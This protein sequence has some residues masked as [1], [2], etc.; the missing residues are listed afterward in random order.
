MKT[1]HILIHLLFFCFLTSP[2]LQAQSETA[3]SDSLSES[4]LMALLMGGYIDSVNQALNFTTGVVEL[5][6]GLASLTVP[7]GYKYL[8]PEQSEYVMTELW[9]N[10]AAETLGMLFPENDGPFS[11]STYAIDI[12]YNPA[13]FINDD[14]ADEIEY[15]ELLEEMQKDTREESKMREKMGMEAVRLV[16]WASQP[17]YDASTK[18]L[19]WAKELQFGDYEENTLNYNLLALG[20]KGYLQMNFIA[21][22]NQLERVK[23]DIPLIIPAINFEEGNR[24]SDFDP[25]LDEVAAIG[26]G[27][28]IAG[29]VLKSAGI[30]AI[31]AKFGKFIIVGLGVAG[32]AVWRFITGRRK[33]DE[34]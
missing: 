25:D 22:M 21:E 14:D 27:G 6:D 34:E 15:D 10:P 4:D 29:K 19:H 2:F 30:F 31:L 20:R 12:T 1:K 13:G 17:Y 9:G 32:T 33:E 28:L 5:G 3:A 7:Q 11:D 24:Y 18:K 23:N 16:G 8:N 26:I